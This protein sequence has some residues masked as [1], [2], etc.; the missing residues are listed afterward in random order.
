MKSP[1][2][3]KIYIT[4]VEKQFPVDAYFPVQTFRDQGF[5]IIWYDFC[6]MKRFTCLN[7]YLRMSTYTSSCYFNE[8]AL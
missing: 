4:H 2:C 3:D 8:V 7:I 1:L 6:G 5:N